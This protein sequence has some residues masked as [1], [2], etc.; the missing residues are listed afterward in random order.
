MVRIRSRLAALAALGVLSA[1]QQ[2]ALPPAPEP[3]PF[4]LGFDM[5]MLMS[6]VIEAAA[7][8]V[9]DSAGEIVY[10]E[11]VQDLAPTDEEG[12]HHVEAAGAMIVEA[13]N[14]LLLPGR[15]PGKADW[16]QFASGL[17]AMGHKVMHAAKAK[18]KDALFQAGADLYSMCVACH[19]VYAL[20]LPVKVDIQENTA[21]DNAE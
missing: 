14:L 4:D 13:G 16:K 11:G 5:K 18:D 15:D 19:Q 10:A 21:P 2:P 9:W 12:W 7:E 6:H 8:V 20:N 3:P 1:C 17:S